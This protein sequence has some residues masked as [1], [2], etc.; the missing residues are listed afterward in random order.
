MLEEAVITIILISWVAIVIKYLTRKIYYS[1]LREIYGEELVRY[2]NRK[3]IHILAGGTVL[4]FP[5]IYDSF[6]IPVTLSLGVTIAL[7]IRRKSNNI[8]EWFQ[9]ESDD[10]EIHFTAM[11]TLLL[12][13]GY[14]LGNPWYGVVPIAFMALG[15]GVTGIVRG[16]VLRRREKS[17]IGNLAMLIVNIPIGSILGVP[18]IAAGIV[19]AIIEKFEFFGGKIDDNVT[20]PLISFLTILAVDALM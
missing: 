7:L 4:L 8:M 14:L 6:V 10:Y 9:N 19:A 5:L 13:L 17:W 12:F 16:I 1:K 3:I 15:D 18:G 11:T 20:I 2:I